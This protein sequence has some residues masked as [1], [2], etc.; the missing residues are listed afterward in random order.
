MTGS[1]AALLLR[2]GRRSILR[3]RWRSLLIVVLILVP[4]AGMVGLAT[5]MQTITPTAERSATDQMGQADL[6][7]YP[8]LGGTETALRKLLPVGSTIDPMFATSETLVV[9]GMAVSVTLRSHDP[10]GVGR[11]MLTLVSGRY[12]A[13]AGEVANSASV[14]K[15][16]SVDLGGTVDLRELGTA[17]VVGII[18]QPLSLAARIVL[19]DPSLA[20]Q[21]M[22][23][24]SADWLVALP[25]GSDADSIG[26][27][28]AD[29]P[30]AAGS[31]AP[32]FSVTTRSERLREASGLGAV[33]LVL[34]G[35][36]LVDASLV[37]A[38]AFAVGVRRRQREIG[39]L[40]AAGASPRQLTGSVLAEALLLGGTASLLGAVVG[41]LGALAL[42]PFLDSLTGHRNPTIALDLPIMAGALALGIAATLVAALGPARTAARLPVLDALSGRRPPTTSSRRAFGLGIAVLVGG[43]ALTAAGAALRLA[44]LAA[45]SASRC[46]SVVRSSG[47]SASARAARGCSD[48]SS[49]RPAGFL[50]RAASRCATL[51]AHGRGTARS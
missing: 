26:L 29:A 35:L 21:A 49:G 43:I 7:V 5:V 28:G 47:R 46:C 30:T 48:S 34:G 12:P 14:E 37:A 9:P 16:A 42:S 36:A 8:G 23:S 50:S 15:V 51:R 20:T 31:A 13:T 33:T 40:A 45:A 24:D 22:A 3:S 39:L 11:G 17:R 1:T 6:L 44:D 32:Q 41:I 4:V 25:A 19:A 2:I 38:A 27:P 18:E 10:G